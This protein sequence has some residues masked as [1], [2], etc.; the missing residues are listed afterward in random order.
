MYGADPIYVGVIIAVTVTAVIAGHYG[1]YKHFKN[2][3]C[4]CGNVNYCFRNMPLA[5][6]G[7]PFKN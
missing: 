4:G 3:V 7:I 1:L 6:C 5:R 2:P